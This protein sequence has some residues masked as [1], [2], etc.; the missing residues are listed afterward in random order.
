MVRF[1]GNQSREKVNELYG[2]GR[3]GI[4][5]YQPAA[6]HIEA[7][8]NKLFEIMVAGLPVICS[9]FPLWKEIVEGNSCGIC[10]NPQSV[11]EVKQVC[12]YVLDNPKDCHRMGKNG[13]EA[14][15]KRYNWEMEEEKLFNLYDNICMG[16]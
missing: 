16:E 9:D 11:N 5:I 12:K 8:P 1:I 2:K 13:R 7:M 6:N 14:V 10:V 3:A 15:L 4:M